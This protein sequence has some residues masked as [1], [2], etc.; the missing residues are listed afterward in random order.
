MADNKT[1]AQTR[2][3]LIDKDLIKQGWSVKKGNVVEEVNTL[4][5]D[6][7]NKV[8][9]V[10]GDTDDTKVQS[11]YVDYLLLDSKG[12]PLAIIEA[13]KTVKDP[14]MGQAQAEM[15]WAQIVSQTNKNLF[16]YFTNGIEIWFFNKPFEA[17][18]LVKGYHTQE[19]LESRKYQNENAHPF[20]EIKLN[21]KIAN[22]DYQKDAVNAVLNGINKGKRKF[23]LVMATGTGKTRTVMSLVDVLLRSQKVKKVLFLTDRK[24]LRDQAYGDKNFGKYFPDY[25]RDKIYTS[26]INK[27][28]CIYFSTIQTMMEC[29]EEFSPGFFDIII[30]DES[31][32]SIYNKWKDVLTYFDGMKVG[33]TATPSEDLEKDTLKF[34]EC[35]MNEKN[36]R[37]PTYY[38]SYNKAVS[39]GYLVDFK[40]S[41]TKTDLQLKGIKFEDIP[42]DKKN[43]LLAQGYDDTEL[44]FEGTDIEKKV[45]NE[46]TVE[47]WISEF[48]EKSI[49]DSTGTLPGKTI[50]FAITHK[51]AHR[52]WETFNKLEPALMA[53]GFAKIID[54]QVERVDPQE[55]IN[56]FENK[57][58]PR[59]AISVDMLDTGVDV[60][61]IVNLV[62]A[63]PVLSKIKF[64]QM[65]GRGTRK[66]DPDDMKKWCAEKDGF[67]IFDFFNNFEYHELK[68]DDNEINSPVPVPVT[69][70]KILLDQYSCAKEQND[71]EKLSIIKNKINTE[72]D[73][74]PKEGIFVK[75]NYNTLKEIRDPNFWNLAIDLESY[76]T[77]NVVKLMRRRE[78]VNLDV[79]SFRIACERL[80]LAILKNEKD[81][82]DSLK[83]KIIDKLFVLRRSNSI[84]E[85]KDKE[86]KINETI[87]ADFWKDINYKKVNDIETELSSLMKYLQHDGRE[88]IT[89]D[90]DDFVSQRKI[91]EYGPNGE[92]QEEVDKYKPKVEE[93]IYELLESNN[94]ISKLKDIGPVYFT[95][96][97]YKEIE[98][99]LN[100]KEL[101]IT[102]DVLKRLY[103]KPQEDLIELIRRLLDQKQDENKKER[104]I[105]KLRTYL[106]QNNYA[107]PN[108]INFM[109]ALENVYKNE[110]KIEKEDLR[111]PPFTNF[112]LNTFS[113]QE[114]DEILEIVT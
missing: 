47:A 112:G 30:S 39:E 16:I 36:I 87:S 94:P 28:G 8:Y 71:L 45:L 5:S 40:I 7:K 95:N 78:N 74:L 60:R 98:N 56:D 79:F 106:V 18:R 105:K 63:K 27:H 100:K 4:Q 53:K 42:E 81:K 44:D 14:I 35:E 110:G 49:K 29:Y 9:K 17:P 83:K 61:E 57:D 66:L 68:V 104:T 84:N 111:Q 101:Y 97:E 1:E 3:E 62:F 69:L 89:L 82:F 12:E 46:G 107:D 10:Y 37:I 34:F 80:E 64:W 24:T 51:H 55:L 22:R 6:F 72:I 65:I 32:R 85:V 59:V 58:F 103:G 108:K 99:E 114:I 23:L 13:K 43:E 41:A 25:A 54:S 33:L 102:E 92:F 96:D 75:E 90:M 20:S 73:N 70:F 26:N 88:I 11:K 50:I 19:D 113:K 93:R 86:D 2:E 91:I 31:H 109:R 38:Y 21:D 15:Y 76:L 67:L 77:E 52:I 48:M